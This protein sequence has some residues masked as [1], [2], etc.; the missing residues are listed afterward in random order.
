MAFPGISNRSADM[1][2]GFELVFRD[3]LPGRSRYRVVRPV[4]TRARGTNQRLAL[5]Q[6]YGDGRPCTSQAGE[7]KKRQRK[8]RRKTPSSKR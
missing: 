6:D 2:W 5:A 7:K 3:A 1:G 4:S 8:R